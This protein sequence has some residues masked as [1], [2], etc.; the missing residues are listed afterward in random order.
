MTD[1]LRE[2]EMY[3]WVFSGFDLGF[4][5]IKDLLKIKYNHIKVVLFAN[6]EGVQI[7]QPKHCLI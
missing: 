6:K 3:K 2:G 4:I 7:I 5:F 1:F